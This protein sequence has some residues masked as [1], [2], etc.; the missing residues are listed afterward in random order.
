[1]TRR[2]A[3]K[4]ASRITAAAKPQDR[5]KAISVR[6]PNCGTVEVVAHLDDG[7]CPACWN[8]LTSE[9]IDQ[10]LAERWELVDFAPAPVGW[11]AFHLVPGVDPEPWHRPVAGWLTQRE[12]L[13]EMRVV[14]AVHVLNGELFPVDDRYLV[15]VVGPGED[16]DPADLA[17]FLE[18]RAAV[19]RQLAGVA[20]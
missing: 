12:R 3:P 1:M 13:G 10:A 4:G 14:A 20:T 7:H 5:S 11:R 17:A 18:Y 19:D 2:S 6:C 15:A 16:L 9:R 8:T